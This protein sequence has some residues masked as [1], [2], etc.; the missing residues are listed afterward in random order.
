MKAMLLAAGEGRRMRPLT[1]ECPKPL[2]RVRG[3]RLL[4]YHLEKLA[5]IGVQE[6]IINI[7]W[8][9]DQ[10]RAAYPDG[11]AYGLQ[12][13]WS[14]EPN[15]LETGGGVFQALPALGDAPFLLI[16]G[17]V[18]TDF[19]FSR[20]LQA[21]ASLA[22]LVLTPNPP[23]HP[24]GDFHLDP[25]SGRVQETGEPRLTFSGIS[26]LRPELFEHCA[27]GAFRLAPLL[28]AA[29]P[30]GQVSGELHTGMWNDVG[31]PERLAALENQ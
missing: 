2:L 22:H 10:F 4:D 16:N 19:D 18:F 12:I 28:T 21:P 23:H 9:A 6:V 31:T 1:L 27:P 24:Q 8:L 7:S 25:K 3:Q 30:Q 26:R 5:A 11:R 29:M 15:C 17:D 20:L 13:H 14:Y